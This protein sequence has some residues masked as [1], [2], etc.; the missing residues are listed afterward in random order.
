MFSLGRRRVR[1][2]TT[3]VCD[4]GS[5]EGARG[6]W[7]CSLLRT[8]PSPLLNL[9]FALPERWKR[10]RGRRRTEENGLKRRSRS[11][12]SRAGGRRGGR[13]GGRE[14]ANATRRTDVW[15]EFIAKTGFLATAR[16]NNNRGKSQ[17][18]ENCPFHGPQD[19][20]DA[21][22]NYVCIKVRPGIRRPVY[23]EVRATL[24]C[25]ARFISQ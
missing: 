8:G 23:C 10:K 9:S 16:E 1:E 3:C 2:F 6:G 22:L 21:R 5:N 17:T 13:G 14:A 18:T 15:C 25:T 19:S 11:C 24:F 7:S 12:Y 20:G 4:E